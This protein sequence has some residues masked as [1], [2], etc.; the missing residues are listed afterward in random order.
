MRLDHPYENLAGGQWLRGNL[1][2]HTTRSDGRADPQVV[3]DHYAR[4]G[5]AFLMLSDHDIF[6]S[7]ADYAKLDAK[8]LV[9]I[10]G[11]EVTAGGPHLLHVDGDRLVAPVPLRQEIINAVNASRGFAIVNHPNWHAHFD[12]CTASQL[13]EWV[14]YTGMEIFN[15]VIARLDGSPYALGKWDMQ[16][17]RGRRIWGF[18]NDDMHDPEQDLALG[19]NVAYVT[20]RS[21]AGVV[22]A[23]RKGRFYASTG[24]GIDRI[25]VEGTRVRVEAKEAQ[26]IVVYQKTGKRLAKADASVLEVEVPASAGYVRFEC[27]GAGER[28]AWTQPFFVAE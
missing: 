27:W 2:T 22:D 8:G 5:Y 19:W 21:V 16:L 18:A 17:A 24:V 20:D 15:G 7:P 14:G 23:L 13:A 1:H 9:L 3:I 4:L 11:N 28:F 12:H 25:S 26:R 10:P 6:T